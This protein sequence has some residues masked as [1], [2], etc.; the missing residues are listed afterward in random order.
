MSA[1]GADRGAVALAERT[2][3]VELPAMVALQRLK[4]KGAMSDV[5]IIV[6]KGI[7]EG[8]NGLIA[9]GSRPRAGLRRERGQFL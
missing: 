6:Q 2:S 5:S 8:T 9:T 7:T 3:N 4:N 1:C